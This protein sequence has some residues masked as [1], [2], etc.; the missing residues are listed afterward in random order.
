M[1]LVSVIIP[2]LD[3]AA[4]VSR[5]LDQFDRLPGEWQII[6]ADSG[7]SDGTQAIAR[8]HG[9]CLVNGPRGRGA[10]MNAGAAVATGDIL[11]FLHAD[12]FLPEDAHQ[13]ITAAL[14]DPA[15]AATAFHLTMDGPGRRY[16]L[17]P[18]ISS[19]RM[20]VQRTFFGDQAIAVRRAD[21][22]RIGGYE[23]PFLMEDVALSRRLRREGKL[24]V[25]GAHVVTSSRRFEHGGMIRTLVLMTCMQAAYSLG[26]SADR[27]AR[28]YRHV[29]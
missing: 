14:A 22:E 18:Y 1:S 24:R 27:L 25:L 8:A 15:V 23:E 21:F 2:T 10:G 12:T 19:I 13:Q 28:I 3:E 9:A 16:R 7:S 29:R 17:M 5:T 6:V 26:V 11:L 20:R 4:V